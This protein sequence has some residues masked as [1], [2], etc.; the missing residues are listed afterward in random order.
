MTNSISGKGSVELP[1]LGVLPAKPPHTY[2]GIAYAML[3]GVRILADASPLPALP[4]ALVCAHT[5]ECA[6]KAHLSKSGDDSRVRK[7]DVRHNLTAL[8]NL[9]FSSGL[10]I[11]EDPPG[12][13]ACLSHIHNSP[14]YLRYSTGVHSIQTPAPEPMAT[15]LAALVDQV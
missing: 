12:W 3:P 11:Q 9:S 13:V 2:L 8:W 1:P 15:E 7:S 5:L 14:Y 10:N 4:L 6:L